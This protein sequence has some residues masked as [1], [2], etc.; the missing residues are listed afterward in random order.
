MNNRELS[1]H[2]SKLTYAEALTDHQRFNKLIKPFGV[3]VVYVYCGTYALHEAYD[4]LMEMQKWGRSGMRYFH[5]FLVLETQNPDDFEWP[6]KDCAVLIY[7]T[8]YYQLDKVKKRDYL[9]AIARN[10]YEY[11]ARSV[12]ASSDKDMIF[13]KRK[14]A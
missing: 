11:G 12:I 7:E 9:S 3:P 4:H 2:R 6:V 10:L 8:S 13:Y 14:A 5:Y 1:Q